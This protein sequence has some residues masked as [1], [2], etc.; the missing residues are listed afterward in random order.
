[1]TIQH[2]Q[3][4]IFTAKYSRYLPEKE[5]RETW[6]EACARVMDMHRSHFA[7][8]AIDD[9]LTKASQ[10]R[11][12]AWCWAASAPCN[13]AASR[14]SIKT[15]VLYN[16]TTSYCDRPR[17]FQEA[18]WLLLCGCGVGFSVQHHHIAKLPKLS[19][20]TGK[21]L[22]ITIDDT[23]EGWADALGHLISSYCTTEAPIPSSQ[24]RVISY[25]YDN[26]RPKGSPIFRKWQSAGA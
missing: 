6:S 20:P 26:I 2:L 15:H 19:A 16:C 22:L 9:L 13:L 4:Y 5:R 23:I 14:F 7:Q 25:S 3:D 17:F 18:L 21:Q 10:A 1:M 12:S 11:M 24:A 8:Y